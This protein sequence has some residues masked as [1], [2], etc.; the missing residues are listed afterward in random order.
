MNNVTFETLIAYLN[1][2]LSAEEKTAVTEYL[3]TEPDAKQQLAAA[4]QLLASMEKNELKAPEQ[5]L[6]DRVQAAFRN[7]VTQSKSR[8]QNQAELTFD[9][10]T[11][12]L[13]LGVRGVPQ[14]RQ[15]LFHEEV[16]DIDIQF[17][18]DPP[19]NNL[20]LRGQMMTPL[21]HKDLEGIAVALTGTTNT[22]ARRT[23]TDK[24][25]RFTFTQL[26]K[27]DYRL[28]ATLDTHDIVLLL[29]DLDI[30]EQGEQS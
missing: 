8:L 4:Q 20:T 28:Q 9:S 15:L 25:G 29:P 26:Q 10:W 30:P 17:V 18:N 14:E 12:P 23:L 1:D 13:S 5:K 19:V 27:G 22:V 7:K 6:L 21:E 24:Y 2:E 11:Q 16:V 3:K